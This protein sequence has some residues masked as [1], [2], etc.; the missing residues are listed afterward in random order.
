MATIEPEVRSTLLRQRYVDVREHTEDLAA[1]LTPED[2]MVQSM[3]DVS[4]TKWHRGHTT[5]F[6]ETFVLPLQHSDYRAFHPAFGYIFNSYYETIGSRQ[7]RDQR[8]VISRPSVGEVADYRAH[9]DKAMAELFDSGPSDQTLSLV[10]LGLNHEQQHQELLLMDIKHVLSCNPLMPEYRTCDERHNA[11]S[12]RLGWAEH[13]GGTVEIG[14]AGSGFGFD[15]EFP[16]HRAI[17]TPFALADRVVTCGEWIEFI[18]DGGYRR[19]ELWLS[20]GW[21]T[22]NQQRWDS[23]LYWSDDDGQWQV[24]TLFGSRPVVPSEPVCHVSYYEADAYAHWTGL[25][26]PT[27]NEWELIA[28]GVPFEAVGSSHLHPMPGDEVLG[29]LYGEVWQWTVSAYS[30]YPGFRAAAGAVGEYNGKFMVNQH[31]LRGGSVATPPGHLRLTYRNF[32]PPAAQWPFTG[33]RIARDI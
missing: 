9:V 10:E 31:V 17:V 6:F 32:F 26:L 20:D 19:P 14:H 4:P 2:Q 16:R 15:N 21:A 23:P 25:R 33:A 13:E 3:P 24:F 7:P 18:E 12:N 28:S 29:D 11:V 1:P 22:V 27:E 8:G 5:W 30:P